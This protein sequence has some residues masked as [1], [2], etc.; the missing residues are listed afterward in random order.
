VKARRR[1][2]RVWLGGVLALAVGLV[3]LGDRAEANDPGHVPASLACPSGKVTW[4]TG[5]ATPGLALIARVRGVAVG[6]GSVDANGT[7]RIPLTV[8]A[9]AGIYLVTV[10]E[11]QERR[12]I[13][14]FTCFVDL[15][16]GATLT[17]TPPLRQPQQPFFTPTAS[18][19]AAP[20]APQA[21]TVPTS[22]TTV[23]EPTPPTPTTSAS[24]QPTPSPPTLA[25]TATTTSSPPDQSPVALVAVQADDPADPELWEYVV[26]ENRATTALPLTNWRLVHRETG[27]TYRIPAITLPPGELLII[28]S[29]EAQDDSSTGSLFW[30][31]ANARWA[32]GQTAELYTPDGHLV[33]ALTVPLVAAQP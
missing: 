17:V 3:V 1:H 9:P 27:E 15:P 19:S 2:A 29:G 6:G 32:P 18:P 26:V 12:V 14:A 13:A 22:A 20:T 4:L 28:W 11:R 5:T 25:P 16:L 33:S 7:W 30:P 23:E 8:N 21:P 24:E 31:R 10:E